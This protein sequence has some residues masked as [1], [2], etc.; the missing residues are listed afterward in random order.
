MADGKGSVSKRAKI[1]FGLLTNLSGRPSPHKFPNRKSTLRALSMTLILID[2]H[3]QSVNSRHTF[4]SKM[5]PV[6]ETN[7]VFVVY[8]KYK[9]RPDSFVGVRKFSPSIKRNRI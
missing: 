7:H 1:N 6:L 3:T 2:L 8:T 4:S 9:L 5:Q